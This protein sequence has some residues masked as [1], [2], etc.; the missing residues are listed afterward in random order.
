MGASFSATMGSSL[1][2]WASSAPIGAHDAGGVADH[3]G[4]LFRRDA[5][6][7][8]DQVALVLPVVIVDHHH[9]FAP[10]HGR[11]RHDRRLDAVVAELGGASAASRERKALGAHLVAGQALD[12]HRQVEGGHFTRQ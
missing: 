12:L 7:R 6:G 1:S 11:D 10:R 9:E 8:A 5:A 2:R 3:E 4:H